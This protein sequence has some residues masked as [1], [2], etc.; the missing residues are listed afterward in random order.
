MFKLD[1]NMAYLI[2]ALVGDGHISNSRKS[3][4]DRSKDY[5]ISIEISDLD[6]LEKILFPLFCSLV[7]TKSVPKRRKRKG[8]K[9]SSCFLLRNKQLYLFLT[10]EIGMIAGKKEGL[11]IP[12]KIASSNSVIKREFISG[13]F[14]T[15]GGFR[16]K[17]LGFTMKSQILRDEVVGIIR[18]EG[19]KVFPDSWI[20]RYNGLEYYGLRISKYDIVNFLNRFPLRNPEKLMK[21]NYRFFNS[22]GSAGAVKRAGKFFE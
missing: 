19:I 15:D 2:G 1:R 18:S 22:C 5:R 8:K 9:D 3:K 7:L 11:V 21:I 17:S 13:L 14:D 20:S 6:Y 10:S 12:E 4:S 16:G